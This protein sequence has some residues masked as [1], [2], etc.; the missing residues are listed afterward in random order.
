MCRDERALLSRGIQPGPDGRSTH[1]DGL[2][3]DLDDLTCQKIDFTGFQRP[4]RLP[5]IEPCSEQGLIDV[6]VPETGNHML[7]Q[8]LSLI[9]I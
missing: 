4:R 6:D 9:H 7:V 2:L 1:A 5:W 8:K 3:E